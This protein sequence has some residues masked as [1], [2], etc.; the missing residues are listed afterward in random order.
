MV[1]V[2]YMY[3]YMNYAFLTIVAPSP[4]QPSLLMHWSSAKPE[5]FE[6]YTLF[7]AAAGNDERSPPRSRTHANS[8]LPNDSQI[9]YII[10]SPN[11]SSIITQ[12]HNLPVTSRPLLPSPLRAG[13]R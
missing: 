13:R 3:M 11:S 5:T 6:E 4:A 1:N 10:T 7:S 2:V 8:L 12:Q 9:F